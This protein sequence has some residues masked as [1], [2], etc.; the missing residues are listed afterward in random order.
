MHSV[1]GY[2]A[3]WMQRQKEHVY[4]MWIC[5]VLEQIEVSKQDIDSQKDI[6]TTQSDSRNISSIQ[7]EKES[8]KCTKYTKSST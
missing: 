5:E 4:L 1:E 2:W 6:R 8:C 7:R 3:P